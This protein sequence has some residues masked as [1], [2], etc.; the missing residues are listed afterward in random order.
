MKPIMKKTQLQM[1][2]SARQKIA[3]GDKTMMELL[4][5]VNPISDETLQKLIIKRPEVY[6]RYKGYLGTRKV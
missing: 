5:G 4:F 3:D 1:Y 6:S 2:E